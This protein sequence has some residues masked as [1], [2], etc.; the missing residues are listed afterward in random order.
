MGVRAKIC[1]ASPIIGVLNSKIQKC[2]MQITDLKIGVFEDKNLKNIL[3]TSS[4]KNI[5]F[6]KFHFLCIFSLSIHTMLIKSTRT[7]SIIGN[8]LFTHSIDAHCLYVY[9]KK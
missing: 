5:T 9:L 2:K 3:N 8:Y 1:L 4:I 7:V 6:I